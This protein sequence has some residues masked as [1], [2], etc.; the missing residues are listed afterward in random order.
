MQNMLFSRGQGESN[1]YN[2]NQQSSL[3]YLLREVPSNIHNSAS[4]T[5]MQEI[6]ELLY[7]PQ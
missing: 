4:S 7:G 5:I 1:Q 3:K 2:N 6:S